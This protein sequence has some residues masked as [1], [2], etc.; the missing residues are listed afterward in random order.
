[1]RLSSSHK[2]DQFPRARAY[3]AAGAPS[4]SHSPRNS[5]A[6]AATERREDNALQLT[7]SKNDAQDTAEQVRRDS[8]QPRSAEDFMELG[9]RKPMQTGVYSREN[10]LQYLK[11]SRSKQKAEGRVERMPPDVLQKMFPDIQQN[12]GTGIHQALRLGLTS[13]PAASTSVNSPRESQ[14]VYCTPSAR[15]TDPRPDAQQKT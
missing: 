5:E 4:F 6:A 7:R 2:T 3:D 12:P 1:M 8:Q 11:K 15:E 10:L 13:Q 9:E 14:P